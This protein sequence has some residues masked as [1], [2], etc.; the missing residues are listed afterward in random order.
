MNANPLVS[1]VIL[2]RNKKRKLIKCLDS[3]FNLDWS[4]LETICVDNASED[5]S[6]EAVRDRYGDRV[7]ILARSVNSVTQG[8]KSR[9]SSR[10]EGKSS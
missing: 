9:A 2:N 3:V 4:P 7:R 5:G 1:V 6:L 10:R 8:R